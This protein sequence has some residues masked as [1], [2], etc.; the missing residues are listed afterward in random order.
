MTATIKSPIQEYREANELSQAELGELL[1]VHQSFIARIE[2]GERP[3][4]AKKAIKWAPILNI[5]RAALCPE[6]FGADAAPAKQSA[7]RTAKQPQGQAG[8]GLPELYIA[9]ACIGAAAVILVSVLG[10]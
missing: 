3:I 8:F 9:V 1:G 10:H 7:R 6:I 4:T 2:S 5:D